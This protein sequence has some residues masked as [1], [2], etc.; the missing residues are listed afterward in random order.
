VVADRL[1]TGVDELSTGVSLTDD[2]AA[3]SLDL[4]DVAVALEA[5]FGVFVPDV[6]LE[7]MRAY[8][9]V[10]RVVEALVSQRGRAEEGRD[11]P[12]VVVS[13][14]L[15]QP[16]GRSAG[17]LARMDTLTPY[18]AETIVEEAL[19]L[20]KGARLEVAVGAESD[21]AG[22]AYAERLLGSLR[23]RGIQVQVVRE[24]RSA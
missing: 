13:S 6:V 2:L 7:E 5:E 20:G 4:V 10:V 24:A 14:L 16:A 8:G 9:D 21:D 19:R 18:S 12:R 11:Q 23:E 15:T 22:V 3:D 17:A 1:G